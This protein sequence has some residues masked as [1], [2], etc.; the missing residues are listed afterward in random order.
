MQNITIRIVGLIFVAFLFVPVVTAQL[1]NTTSEKDGQ[2]FDLMNHM[3]EADSESYK[4]LNQVINL[5]VQNDVVDDEIQEIIRGRVLDATTR[6]TLPGVNIVVQGTTTGT[7]TLIDGT[8][9]LEVPNLDV[10]LVFTYIT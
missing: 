10:I 7:T 6:E 5:E 4:F 3:P 9:E 1:S 8:F 2:V